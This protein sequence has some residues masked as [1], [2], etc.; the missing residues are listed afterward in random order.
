MKNSST[1]KGAAVLLLVGLVS[2]MAWDNTQ[3]PLASTTSPQRL[4]PYQTSATRSANIEKYCVNG[5]D[6]TSL[7]T[8]ADVSTAA[9]NRKAVDSSLGIDGLV[10]F[11]S[12]TH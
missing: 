12:E 9:T 1:W 2:Y 3:E 11:Y 10:L 4:L 5:V 8:T 7:V 6:R